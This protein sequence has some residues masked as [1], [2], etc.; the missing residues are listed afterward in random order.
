MHAVLR[1]NAG[2]DRPGAARCGD[3]VGVVDRPRRVARLAGVVRVP[4]LGL[5]AGVGARGSA[6]RALGTDRG[7]H[8][9]RL[10]GCGQR[11]DLRGGSGI[12]DEG[13]EGLKD[14][15]PAPV[16][17]PD[18]DRSARRLRL[19]RGTMGGGARCAGT[20]WRVPLT[21]GGRPC[22]D[23]TGCGRKKMKE[24]RMPTT[25]PSPVDCARRVPG[26]RRSSRARAAQRVPPRRR[27]R[28]RRSKPHGH[29]AAVLGT[30]WGVVWRWV[31]E[32]M[33]WVRE[34]EGSSSDVDAAEPPAPL[35]ARRQARQVAD[36]VR[37]TARA[38][39]GGAGVRR[40]HGGSR[41][42]G[43]AD[44]QAAAS[45]RVLQ[46]GVGGRPRDGRASR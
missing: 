26:P 35:L 38:V 13:V 23:R 41:D 45:V 20:M 29:V 43:G 33:V 44:R 46:G 31:D 12:R 14:A 16:R 25:L 32:D 11:V 3:V 36:R 24:P 19:A 42:R 9:G 27:L 30:R 1:E 18:G 37:P 28:H 34:P 39:G 4:N 22:G 21:G 5:G 8:G 40:Q 7:Q 15:P 6:P 2:V 17:E 10:A